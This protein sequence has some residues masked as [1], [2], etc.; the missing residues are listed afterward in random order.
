[1]A[2]ISLDGT[3][4]TPELV[5]KLSDVGG[6][7]ISPTGRNKMQAASDLIDQA[8]RQKK[9]V[10]GVTTGL[11]SN[12]DKVLSSAEL[13]N[14]SLQTLRGRAQ[15][16][17]SPLDKR[18]VRSAMIV[19][20]NTL[21][22]GATGASI[23]CADHLRACVNA[24]V[25][26]VIGESA[27][28]GAS[29]LAWGATMG[30]ALIGEGDMVDAYGHTKGAT[31]VLS[32]VGLTPL[33]LGPRDGL[34][35]ASHGCFSAALGALGVADSAILL[36]NVQAAT[37]LSMQCF[38]ANTSPLREQVLAMCQR[39]GEAQAAQLIRQL[40][41]GASIENKNATR[42]LQDPLSIRNVVQIHGAVYS[43]LAFARTIVESDIN[44]SSD[45]P[46]V[47]VN[48][49]EIVSTGAYH[50]AQ[51]TIAIETVSRALVHLAVAQ[52]ARIGKLV[53]SRFTG[54]P[55]YLAA[56]GN[57]SNGFAPLLKP[58]ESLVSEIIHLAN[59]VPIWPSICSDGVEDSMTNTPLAGKALLTIISKLRRLLAIE[60]TVAAQAIELRGDTCLGEN[61]QFLMNH[62]RKTVKPLNY[63][64]P[65]FSE[66]ESLA[67]QLKQPLFNSP[68]S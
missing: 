65:M 38:G 3:G 34:A 53:A 20:I 48:Q 33:R 13:N 7:A 8:I 6:V 59:P 17:G 21:L 42:R 43:T 60:L 52:L 68:K 5:S 55:Q 27:S 14:F 36:K 39:P 40:L 9:P 64:R 47:L 16:L 54:L 62:I 37:A 30:L 31:T 46:M 2:I 24:N 18:I 56:D 29:D 11:G 58:A 35:L 57:D 50:T 61:L 4:L 26:P 49:N 45:N 32:R 67:E 1:M 15:A 23:A 12:V 22:I 10:Y 66:I 44:G 63:D 19:R 41:T 51:L 25:T 28:I